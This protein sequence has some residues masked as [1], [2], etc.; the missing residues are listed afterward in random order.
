[1]AIL[2]ELTDFARTHA[3]ELGWRLLA[4]L[5]TLLGTWLLL[6]VTRPTVRRVLSRGSSARDRTL[7]LSR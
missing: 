1:M 4:A 2:H 6:R 7:R 3:A 5:A